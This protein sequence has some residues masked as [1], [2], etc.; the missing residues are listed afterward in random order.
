MQAIKKYRVSS[1][2]CYL[3]DRTELITCF[4]AGE[5]YDPHFEKMKV[6]K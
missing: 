1:L 2:R 5:S 4:Q 6:S 3:D